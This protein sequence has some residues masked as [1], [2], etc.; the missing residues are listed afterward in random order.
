MGNLRDVAK[1]AGVSPSTVSFVMNDQRTSSISEDTRKRVR[2]AAAELGYKPH[3]IARA[4]ATGRT[5]MV[6]LWIRSLHSTYY[7][8]F[9]HDIDALVAQSGYRLMINRNAGSSAPSPEEEDFPIDSAD[10]I[11]AIDIPGTVERFIAKYPDIPIVQVGT[12]FSEATDYVGVE[13]RTAT[14]DALI[15]LYELGRR[16]IC[17]LMD[18]LT[19]YHGPG[20]N[21]M[22]VYKSTMAELGLPE[23]F[24]L[25]R[26]QSYEAA[27]EA[28]FEALDS[29]E[30]EID[31]LACYNDDM[32][33]SAMCG[34][35]ERG[36]RVPSDVAVTG[37][38]NIPAAEYLWPTLST[39]IHPWQD[40]C[41]LGWQTL[42][43]RI[44]EPTRP[45]QRIELSA[46]FIPRRSTTG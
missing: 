35:H 12:H 42:L 22:M 41:V 23:R 25:A 15:H 34:L 6:G 10:G 29:G 46:K 37:C 27:R 2:A 36:V 30:P 19:Y 17:Y 1:K 45:P 16:R 13:L 8:Q 21:R 3:R 4:L 43:N 11:F 7:T 40:I 44:K 33:L 26:N 20:D 31:A 14:R 39:I 5:E 32:A 28:I 9:I 38:D 24:I 18:G